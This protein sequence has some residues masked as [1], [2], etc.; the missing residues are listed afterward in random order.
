MFVN[1]VQVAPGQVEHWLGLGRSVAAMRDPDTIRRLW[2]AVEAREP[3]FASVHPDL[4]HP[5]TQA[6]GAP[7]GAR[8]PLWV[9]K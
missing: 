1:L 7:P 5:W 8:R 3:E 4:V 2:R 6:S 9:A